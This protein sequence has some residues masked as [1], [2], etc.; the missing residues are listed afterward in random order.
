MGTPARSLRRG[1]SRPETIANIGMPG[2]NGIIATHRIARTKS[3]PR[4]SAGD[5]TRRLRGSIASTYTTADP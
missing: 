2:L 3:R 5:A 4:E 1:G